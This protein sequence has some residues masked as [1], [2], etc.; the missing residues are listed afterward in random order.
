M[1]DSPDPSNGP[2]AESSEFLGATG[3]T[4]RSK[5][6]RWTKVAVGLGA[7]AGVAVG[8]TAIA[9]AATSSTTAP[10]ASSSAGGATPATPPAGSGHHGGFGRGGFGGGGLG[11]GGLG[12]GVGGPG[13]RVI[14]GQ[15]TVQGPNGYETLE[16]QTAR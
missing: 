10:S 3:P 14:H 5:R 4:N 6:S 9:G 11:G 13:G 16:V 1:I 2:V 8:A 15:Y 7:A 12:L